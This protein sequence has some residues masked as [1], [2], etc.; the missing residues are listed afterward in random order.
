MFVGGG[1]AVMIV[2]AVV[3]HF[4]V[5]AKFCSK[6]KEMAEMAEL[7]TFLPNIRLQNA[8]LGCRLGQRTK[9]FLFG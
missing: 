9:R 7:G 8:I 5:V 6:K 2:V 1:D 3:R 4:V